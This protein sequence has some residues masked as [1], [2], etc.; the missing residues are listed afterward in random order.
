MLKKL[1][2]E[3]NIELDKFQSQ[4]L[5]EEIP[6]I[7][8]NSAIQSKYQEL[9]SYIKVQED[10]YELI[11]KQISDLSV[12]IERL[13]QEFNQKQTRLEETIS[14]K[15]K[16]KAPK[17]SYNNIEELN[18]ILETEQQEIEQYTKEVKSLNIQ[19]SQANQQ[20][21]LLQDKLDFTNT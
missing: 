19:I 14:Y 7:P 20:I 3:K 11:K 15:L 1:Q 16:N 4:T 10:E 21:R 12:Q 17:Q 9:D 6:T 18:Q 13:R 5:N 2:E 8:Q